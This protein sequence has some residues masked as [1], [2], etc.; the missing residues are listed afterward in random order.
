MTPDAD[1]AKVL[2]NAPPQATRLRS[3]ICSRF[4]E[5]DSNAWCTC[6]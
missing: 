3:R 6:D 5:I 4:T 1:I 2:L